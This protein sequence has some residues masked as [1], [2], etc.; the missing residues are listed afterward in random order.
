MVVITIQ[1][2]AEEENTINFLS[3]EYLQDKSA[4]VK[5]FTPQKYRGHNAMDL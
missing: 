5:I 1:L 2:N 4:L 3:S